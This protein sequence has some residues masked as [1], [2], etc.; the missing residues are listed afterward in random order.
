MVAE[1]A[2]AD[3]TIASAPYLAF[4]QG[5]EYKRLDKLAKAITE[6]TLRFSLI[7][8]DEAHHTPDAIR[9]RIEDACSL[10]GYTKILNTTA[11]P[12]RTHN[13]RIDH[14]C[15][16]KVISMLDGLLAPER[17][18]LDERFVK[19]LCFLEVIDGVS[20]ACQI[21][22]QVGANLALCFC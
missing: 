4:S 6:G 18:G 21:S 12:F 14:D 8:F 3:I 5:G 22:C 10:A 1:V 2:K 15:H 13:Q 17:H 19:D 11:T 9:R 20:Q 7:V 16:T